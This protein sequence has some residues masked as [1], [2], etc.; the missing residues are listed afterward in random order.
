MTDLDGILE[1]Y[2]DVLRG[3]AASFDGGRR[4][5]PILAPDLTFEGPIAGHVVGAERFIGGV[6]GF[7]GT[8]RELRMLHT[9]RAADEAATLYDAEMPGGTVRF[10]EFFRCAGGRISSLRLLYDAEDYRSKGGR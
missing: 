6:S 3:G 7:V 9:L 2:Y 8:V 4:L 5:R 1:T 10:A